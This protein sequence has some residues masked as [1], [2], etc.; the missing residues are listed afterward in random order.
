M[1]LLPDDGDGPYSTVAGFIG[2]KRRG[3]RRTSRGV[4]GHIAL[5]ASG[6]IAGRSTVLEL[7]H[8][9][10]G[11]QHRLTGGERRGR[12]SGCGG[13][14]GWPHGVLSAVPARRFG[15]VV[16]GCE[17]A[18]HAKAGNGGHGLWSMS[19]TSPPTRQSRRVLPSGARVPARLAIVTE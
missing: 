19:S 1:Q 9:L 14:G 8:C 6:E 15:S 5:I 16:M 18:T 10:A 13:R 17:P 11:R 7:T 12:D 2:C 4:A 3:R